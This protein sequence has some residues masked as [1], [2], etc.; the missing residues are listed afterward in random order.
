MIFVILWSLGLRLDRPLAYFQVLLHN[1]FAVMYYIFL[2]F[3]VYNVE[4]I[5]YVMLRKSHVNWFHVILSYHQDHIWKRSKDAGDR[6]Y[7]LSD[8]ERVT[9]TLYPAVSAYFYVDARVSLC[10]FPLTR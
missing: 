2:C 8:P 1:V 9:H 7:F 4:E 5:N 3:A 6:I 10:V